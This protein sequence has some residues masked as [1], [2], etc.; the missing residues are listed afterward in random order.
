MPNWI[1]P[2]MLGLV[3]LDALVVFVFLRRRMAATFES[4]GIDF[5]RI[6]QVGRLV[7]ERLAAH[8]Q[9][10][11]SGQSADLPQALRRAMEIARGIAGEHAIVLDEPSL[12]LVVTGAVC[13]RK[14]ASRGQVARA[15]A[16]LD[17]QNSAA[18]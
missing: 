12:R 9:S 6:H 2:L 15:F 11:W 1:W 3:V 13:G 10:S 4:A 5:A 7:D 14:L 16:V 17:A 8:M 18:A